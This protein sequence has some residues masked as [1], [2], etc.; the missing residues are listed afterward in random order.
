MQHFVDNDAA[1]FQWLADHPAGFVINT[2]RNPTAAYLILHR[3]NCRTISGAPSRGS[4][5]TGDYT[6]ICGH[7]KELEAFAR[8]LGGVAR[9]CQ[10]CLAKPRRDRLQES[11]A[12]GKKPK[13]HLA[14]HNGDGLESANEAREPTARSAAGNDDRRARPRWRAALTNPWAVGVGAPLIVAALVAIGA[15]LI[16]FISNQ[17]SA[18]SGSVT[19]QSGRNVVGVWI[20]T[21]S[22]QSDSGYAHIGPARNAGINYPASP[23]V[24]YSYL[25]PHGGTYSVHVGCG[26]S[27]AHWASSNYSPVL[28][29]RTAQLTCDDPTSVP[30]PGL[31]PHGKCVVTAD[32]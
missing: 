16:A 24:T 12:N 13:D 22:G 3:A 28:E 11:A 30:T 31:V 32:R 5:F 21:S 9:P 8:R 18:L 1:Y 19:C 6:K 10:L 14:N 26:G 4:T 2:G 23:E 7:R 20:A 17:D 29:K 15:H 27:G 25:L